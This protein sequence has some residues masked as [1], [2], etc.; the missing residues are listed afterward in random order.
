MTGE[1]GRSQTPESL[2]QE[3]LSASKHNRKWCRGEAERQAGK[4]AL[5]TTAAHPALQ[6]CNTPG[7]LKVVSFPSQGL[8]VEGFHTG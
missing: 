4:E 8:G 1:W 7:M 3:G 5:P 6:R 2:E